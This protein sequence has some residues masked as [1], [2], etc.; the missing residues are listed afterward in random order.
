MKRKLRMPACHE[1]LRPLYERAVREGRIC[2]PEEVH[3]RLAAVEERWLA[4]RKSSTAPPANADALKDLIRLY[5]ET[6]GVVELTAHA[7]AVN[8]QIAVEVT[9][10]RGEGYRLLRGQRK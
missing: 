2:P 1:N 9:E 6:T 5:C 10:R 7:R 8:G 3:A 4:E